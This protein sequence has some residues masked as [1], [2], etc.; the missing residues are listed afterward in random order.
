MKINV[1][2]ADLSQQIDII[3]QCAN[4]ISDEYTKEMLIGAARLLSQICFAV[5]EEEPIEIHV[6][7]CD[8]FLS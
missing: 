8:K 2:C 4:A 1:S 6:E 7:A 3:D 5:E